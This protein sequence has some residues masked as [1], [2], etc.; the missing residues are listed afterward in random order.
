M[1]KHTF[2]TNI[3]HPKN[4]DFSEDVECSLYAK[5]V[6]DAYY[7]VLEELTQYVK[8]LDSFYGFNEKLKFHIRIV[9]VEET[10]HQ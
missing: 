4:T 3:Y 2:E 1:T 9:D 7:R 10:P 6:A 8:H 5:E